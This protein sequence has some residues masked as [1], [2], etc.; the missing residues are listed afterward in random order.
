MRGWGLG[1]F[2]MGRARRLAK[3]GYVAFA[4]DMFGD[5][6]QAHDLEGA[7]AL[8]GPLRGNLPALRQRARAA[9]S[10]L[11]VAPEEVFG[12]ADR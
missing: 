3:L 10:K 4:A 5:R 12:T 6:R 7:S 9:R 11:A 1:D 2:A 8:I